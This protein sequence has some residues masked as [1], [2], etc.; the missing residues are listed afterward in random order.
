[1]F[2]PRQTC[3]PGFLCL[4]GSGAWGFLT[5]CFES[6]CLPGSWVL[7]WRSPG[8]VGR[9]GRVRH[10]DGG[11]VWRGFQVPLEGSRRVQEGLMGA[12]LEWGH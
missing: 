8:M 12:V 7:E 3:F 10:E 9:V 5:G 1:M 6:Q 2:M 4:G 11:E